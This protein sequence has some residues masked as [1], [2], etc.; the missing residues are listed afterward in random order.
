MIKI[1]KNK[2]G[3]VKRYVIL[4]I[5]LLIGFGIL[6][7]FL[8]RMS[9]TGRIDKELCHQSVI[10]RATLPDT[11]LI[12]FKDYVP[13]KCKTAKYCLTTKL[14]GKG[15]CSEFRDVKGVAKVRVSSDLQKQ[16]QEIKMF[17][18][19]EMADCWAMMGEGKIQIFTR[20]ASVYSYKKRCAV[21]SRIAF[22]QEIKEN[23]KNNGIK[24]MANY[25]VSHKVPGKEI[26]YLDF[27]GGG[28]FAEDMKKADTNDKINVNEKAIIFIEAD[29]S[30]M[31]SWF[32]IGSGGV[33]GAAVGG[34][35]GFVVGSFIGS[36]IIGGPITGAVGGL[37]GFVGGSLLGG[38]TKSEIDDLR[39]KVS[40][41]AGNE[42][43]NYNTAS[44]EELG[45]D[46][47]EDI[48]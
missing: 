11:T 28:K 35:I 22:S 18:A 32:W 17:I 33:S 40:Y 15:E 24:G 4:F 2:K 36:P 6:L 47:F 14:L 29:A 8:F 26:S 42:L 3:E 34:K 12:G 9:L 16:E 13:L 30:T 45:C 31:P 41:I 20:K 48:P 27:L 25:L 5:L 37:F 44:L 19:R 43:I 46:S 21:C 10:Y 23:Y 39:G 1:M 38:M 7:I